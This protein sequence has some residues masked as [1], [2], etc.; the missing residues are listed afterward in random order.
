MKAKKGGTMHNTLQIEQKK[1]C[2]FVRHGIKHVDYKNP[3]FLAQFVNEFGR[4]LPKRITG[5]SVKYQKKVSK[6]VKRARHLGLLPFVKGHAY[7]KDSN[8]GDFK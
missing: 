7:K 3:D 4:I 6:A 1:Y 8:E 2:R 5:T